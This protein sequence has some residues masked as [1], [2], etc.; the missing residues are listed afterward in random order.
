MNI[1]AQREYSAPDFH[2]PDAHFARVFE[3]LGMHR[4][5]GVLNL[6]T[7]HRYTGVYEFRH[8]TLKCV[9]LFDK[10]DLSIYWAPEE[11]L[12]ST[13]CAIIARYSTAFTTGDALTDKR[14]AH[15]PARGHV[16]AFH[17]VP[18]LDAA[19]RCFGAICHWDYEPRALDTREMRL[20]V[21]VAPIVAR[22]LLQSRLKTTAA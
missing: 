13:Y 21:T 8:R 5:L 20:L 19:Q 1:A 16:R 9:A 3:Q 7:W 10:D 6:R 14:L 4:A 12:Q 11:S 18:L 22:S 2:E 15:H 17:G